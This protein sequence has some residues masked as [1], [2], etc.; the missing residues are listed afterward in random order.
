MG[1]SS[2]GGFTVFLASSSFVVEASPATAE[3]SMQA[4]NGFVAIPA[5][6][7]VSAGLFAPATRRTISS[8]AIRTAGPITPS[9]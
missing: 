6:T 7:D 5:L 3:S 2:S 8:S 4:L 1:A 9:A